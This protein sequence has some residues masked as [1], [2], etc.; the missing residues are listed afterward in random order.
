ME[1]VLSA[2]FEVPNGIFMYIRTDAYLKFV[3]KKVYSELKGTKYYSLP[4]LH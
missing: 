3:I 4:D 1:W 2:D